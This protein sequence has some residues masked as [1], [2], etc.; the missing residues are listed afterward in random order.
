[1]HSYLALAAL[2]LHAHDTTID[3]RIR[4][5]ANNE[6]RRRQLESIRVLKPLEP[7]LNMSMDAFHN[8]ERSRLWRERKK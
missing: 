2:S 1:M 4:G 6:G 8:L 5:C 3:E 7:R